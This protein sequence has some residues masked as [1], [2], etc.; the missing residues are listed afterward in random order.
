MVLKKGKALGGVYMHDLE[1]LAAPNLNYY[2]DKSKRER[3][4]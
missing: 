3:E 1:R 2:R 4:S